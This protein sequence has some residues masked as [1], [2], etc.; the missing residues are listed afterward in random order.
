MAVIAM[1]REMATLGRDVAAGLAER[2]GLV[3]VHHELVAQDIAERSGM[4][5]SEV[6]RFLEGESSLLQRWRID[7]TRMSRYTAEEILELAAKGN[8]L[9]RGWGATYLLRDVPHALCVRICA[10]M[11]DRERVLMERIGIAD[12]AM[13]RREIE[14]NDSAHNGTMQ[15]L[16]GINWTDPALYAL[17][18]NTARIPVKDCVDHIVEVLESAPFKE[19]EVSRKALADQLILSKVHSA[20]D[21]RFGSSTS[22]LGIDAQ[23]DDGRVVLKGALSDDRMI[24]EA[25]RL[26]HDIPGVQR[27]ECQIG[28]LGF[29]R[30]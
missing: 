8:V 29:A 24:A 21:K 23:V 19:T 27:V 4:R 7:R 13:A 28:H 3:V 18:L 12:R 17:V 15:R 16:F 14:K 11:A 22:A 30:D 5:E 2:L 9:I 10:P 20:L 6:Q 26:M 1:T 25:V